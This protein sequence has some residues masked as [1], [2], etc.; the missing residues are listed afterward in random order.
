MDT[1]LPEPMLSKAL[2]TSVTPAATPRRLGV[3]SELKKGSPWGPTPRAA[4]PP[5]AVASKPKPNNSGSAAGPSSGARFPN[6][7]LGRT[8]DSAALAASVAIVS[9]EDDVPLRWDEE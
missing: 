1:R 7:V 8:A 9:A 5:T 3:L 2:T 4:T 6:S